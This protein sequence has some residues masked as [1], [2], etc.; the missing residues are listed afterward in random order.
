MSNT[1]TYRNDS[2]YFKALGGYYFISYDL[3]IQFPVIIIMV[4]G[5]DFRNLKPFYCN[6]GVRGE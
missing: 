5:K 3:V 4:F 6:N 1:L 2:N